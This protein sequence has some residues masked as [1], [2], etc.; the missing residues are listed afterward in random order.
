MKIKSDN[1]SLK[2]EEN[3]ASKISREFVDQLPVISKLPKDGEK[4]DIRF[5]GL[6]RLINL[7]STICQVSYQR[8]KHVGEVHRAAHYIGMNIL[9]CL[10][11]SPEKIDKTYGNKLYAVLKHN[12]IYRTQCIL[13]DDVLSGA[14]DILKA[15]RDG[16]ITFNEQ[17][18]KLSEL[19]D[20]MPEEMRNLARNK[21]KELRNGKN[22][23]DLTLCTVTGG[24]RKS[25]NNVTSISGRR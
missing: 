10:Y 23:S 12:E 9:F 1:Q 15:A 13:L 8:F 25:N 5:R 21:M 22:I 19:V 18:E 3:W 20:A 4:S 6:S 24:D 14:V 16:V 2:L 7:A 11:G 17:D